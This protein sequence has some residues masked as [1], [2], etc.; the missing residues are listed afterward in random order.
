MFRKAIIAAV[1]LMVLTVWVLGI[2]AIMAWYYDTQ[3]PQPITWTPTAIRVVDHPPPPWIIQAVPEPEPDPRYEA[4]MELAEEW[5][6]KLKNR[7]SDDETLVLIVETIF[8]ASERY[9]QDPLR[10]AAIIAVESNYCIR[11]VSHCG[12]QGLMQLMPAKQEAYGI[13]DP[14]DIEVNIDGGVRFLAELSRR[15]EHEENIIAGYNAGPGR[16]L[17]HQW[18]AET[19]H[20]V[21]KVLAY[22]GR[23]ERAVNPEPELAIYVVKS[24]DTLGKIAKAHNT[25]VTTLASR[26]GIKNVDRIWPGQELVVI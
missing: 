5:N 4:V 18:P 20:Y 6:S 11:A 12:A 15:F 23:L 17:R 22:R 1:L 13:I 10:T 26:N 14:Y 24:G 8:A 2:V 21:P 16:A 3:E 7:R 25:T 9:E 19:R